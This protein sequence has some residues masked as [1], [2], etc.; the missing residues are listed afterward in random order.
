[1]SIKQFYYKVQQTSSTEGTIGLA[2]TSGI[3]T[4]YR[5]FS[6][7]I[8]FDKEFTYSIVNNSNTLEWEYGI[9]YIL[10]SAGTHTLVRNQVLASSA[11]GLVSFTSGTKSID[12]VA[13]N[14]S[15]S[16]LVSVS[17]TTGLEYINSTYLVDASTG[18]VT[19]NLPSIANAFNSAAN[20][21]AVSISVVLAATT[22]S[23]TEQTNAITLVPSGADTIRGTTSYS[24]S[25]L[26]DYIQLIANPGS[27]DWVVLDPIQDSIYP[28]GG[29]GAVQF[30]QDQQFGYSTGLYWSTGTNSLLIG[31]SGTSSA[32]IQLSSDSGAIFNKQNEDQDFEVRG[33]ESGLLFV[34]ASA[35]RVGVGTSSPSTRL[36]V[37][38][39]GTDG[40][41]VS[42]TAASSVPTIKLQNSYTGIAAGDDVGAIVFNSIDSASNSTDYAK[43]LGEF[44]NK[45]NGSEEG[46]L[47]VLVNK[48]GV[49]QTV[50]EYAYSGIVLGIDNVN[51]NGIIIGEQNTNNGDNILLGYYSDVSGLTNVSV[52]HTNTI[53]SGNYNGI[54]GKNHTVSGENLWI[55]GGSGLS[56]TG[57]NKTYL[58]LDSN[59]YLVVEN[60]GKL[61]YRGLNPSGNL[62]SFINEQVLASSGLD[63]IAM[64]YYN[65]AGQAKTGVLINNRIYSSTSGSE[66]TA[67][68]TYISQSGSQKKVI[69]IKQNNLVVGNNT[70]VS[71][72]NLVYGN[73][74]TISNSG[75]I[76]VGSGCVV[77]GVNN[78]VVGRGN[79]IASGTGSN[80][81]VFGVSNTVDTSGNSNI[82]V[83]GNSN[84]VD[85]DYSITVG[86]NNTNS[87]LYGTI[88][89]FD[90]GANGSYI[91]AVGENNLVTTDSSVAVG[92][93]NASNNTGVNSQGFVFGIGNTHAGSGTGILVGLTNTTS[94]VGGTLIGT[95]NFSSGT[96]NIL[97]GKD[98]TASG[99]N[100]IVIGS[101]YT[102]STSNSVY[103]ANSGAS[104]TI[105]SNDI[106][107]SGDV[108]IN[109]TGI[110]D[111]VQTQIGNNYVLTS[112]TG[113]LTT[114]GVVV[115]M[116]N[117]I[118]TGLAIPN[119]LTI[120]FGS[121]VSG[122]IVTCTGLSVVSESV[123]NST[124]DGS[125]GGYYKTYVLPLTTGTPIIS[126]EP[127]FDLIIARASGGP[128]VS[129]NAYVIG[130]R[131]M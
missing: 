98:I 99:D 8:G 120:L 61:S 26:N 34:D 53:S 51:I 68:E 77:S 65:A 116:P 127:D 44:I 46:K 47:S 3:P 86:L 10:N 49:L 74:N 29:N 27:T 102:Q 125:A 82:M 45:T 95:N 87:G 100:I 22:G 112:G 110:M 59:N 38:V 5:A 25:I 6:D 32:T 64:V 96:N 62:V 73:S 39:S 128:S 37:A 124:I 71:G 111:L 42:S 130:T 118:T 88:V 20:D 70:S 119:M 67:L 1:M 31:N 58:V 76:V 107:L 81:S 89:G 94:G 93:N 108:I 11:T 2:I 72:D 84:T 35:N 126:G 97:I 17:A 4:G 78:L 122:V 117:P 85:E 9:G 14:P 83:F 103:I 43:I 41:S 57:V 12:L 28:S 90:N 69:D 24:V 23:Q 21:Q 16:N 50:A 121:G 105:S 129:V 91:T 114:T 101:G 19:L 66:Y 15:I 30:A 75:N 106:K 131:V 48:D 56:A 92:N 63:S 60:S 7:T 33:S 18:N 36:N 123:P 115:T 13:T 52:G 40:I 113:T 80:I 104:I 55:V 109:N 54:L 79:S